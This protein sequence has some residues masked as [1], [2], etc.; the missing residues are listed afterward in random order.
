VPV[1]CKEIKKTLGSAVGDFLIDPDGGGGNPP[2]QVACKL[3]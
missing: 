1:S 2:Q 3:P